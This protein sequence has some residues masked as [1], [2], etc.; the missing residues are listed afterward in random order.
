[1]TKELETLASEEQG[2]FILFPI[3]ERYECY[4]PCELEIDTI[5]G[6]YYWV[7]IIGV[8]KE[9]IRC[10]VDP[11]NVKVDKEPIVGKKIRGLLHANVLGKQQGKLLVQYEI[12]GHPFT[13]PILISPK[14]VQKT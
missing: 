1:M 3:S 5:S 10:R 8:N 6:V 13:K 12:I 9:N 4:I 7:D 2:R 11:V 14:E